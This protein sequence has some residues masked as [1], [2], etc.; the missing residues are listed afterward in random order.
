[1]VWSSINTG[2]V[3]LT[4]QFFAV[5]DFSAGGGGG[6]ARERSNRVGGGYKI[7]GGRRY[8]MRPSH[9]TVTLSRKSVP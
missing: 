3:I 5:Q 8:F 6:K 7:M 2:G 1:M 4:P 9:A